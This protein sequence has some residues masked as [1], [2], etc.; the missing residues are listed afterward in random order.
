MQLKET[1][2]KQMRELL[3][4]EFDSYLASFGKKPHSGLRV[5]TL[6]I[7]P[8]KFEEIS[9]FSLRRVPWTENGFYYD[10]AQPAKHPYYHA[11]LYYLQEPSAMAPAAV[12]P[13]EPGEK[14]LDLCAAPGGKSTELAAKLQ[15]QGV[16]VSN[17]ISASRA[18][19]LL[20]NL[21][22]FGVRNSVVVSEYP[23]KLERY[24]TNWFDKILV[25]APCSGEGMFR[26]DPSIQK[27]WEKQG[28]DFY[29]KLQKEIME[30]AVRMLRPGGKMV[31]STC[32][33]SKEENEGTLSWVL[34]Q[35]PDMYILPI[36][37]EF[38]EGFDH[39]RPQWGNGNP[40]LAETWRIW[41]HRVEGEGHFIALLG[42]D[43]S[44]HA[45]VSDSFQEKSPLLSKETLAFLELCGI[46]PQKECLKLFGER[47]YLLSKGIPGL[48][49]IRILKPGLYLGDQ[50]KNRFEP[51]QPL[52]NAMR[53]GEFP[54]R[55]LLESKDPRVVKYLKG[56]TIEVDFDRSGWQLVCVDGFPLGFGKLNQGMLKNKYSA[57]WRLM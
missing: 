49:G 5:N 32:T 20:K 52:A 40:A 31:Y 18:M 28:P 35:F 13:V 2:Q 1:F 27:A 29:H 4:D 44:D 23:A 14:V 46:D 12:L 50:K 33:F 37:K 34:E 11:G 39:G 55:I 10:N 6:K 16:L 57:G 38:P 51:A 56:E 43:E 53:P 17:D 24:F 42:K 19:A 22:L 15:G 25:D 41:P 36:E 7:T 47:V 26:K 8:E 21:E 9:P 54:E 45:A 48:S 3:G 30:S